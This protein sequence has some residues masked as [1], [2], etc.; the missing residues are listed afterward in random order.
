M[1]IPR[2]KRLLIGRGFSNNKTKISL[3]MRAHYCTYIAWVYGHVSTELR[4]RCIQP[5][6]LC[7]QWR[8]GVERLLQ[9]VVISGVKNRR[10]KPSST[11]KNEKNMTIPPPK[12]SVR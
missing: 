2:R 1:T 8:P 6:R 7:G 4:S 3:D 12:A 9:S 10:L 11:I 5:G